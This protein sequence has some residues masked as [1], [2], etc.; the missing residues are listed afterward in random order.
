MNSPLGSVPRR[1][2]V[3][4]GYGIVAV[5]AID[6][7]EACTG[8]DIVI[9]SAGE[10]YVVSVVCVDVIGAVGSL[11]QIENVASFDDSHG[12]VPSWLKP[13]FPMTSASPASTA[14]RW[15]GREGH[16]TS[17][18]TAITVWR[19]PARHC[20]ATS[21][22]LGRRIR[23]ALCRPGGKPSWGSLWRKSGADDVIE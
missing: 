8:F 21:L 11:E 20:D 18:V 15:I 13:S 9:A 14:L 5:A 3:K 10:N 17:S 4:V 23:N 19:F 6:G 2:V 1:N 16:G 7:V 22:S 12:R